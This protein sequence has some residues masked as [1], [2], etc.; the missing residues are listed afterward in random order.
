MADNEMASRSNDILLE[1]VKTTAR[2]EGQLISLISQVTG[3]SA[4]FDTLIERQ[5]TTQAVTATLESKT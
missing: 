4:K 1:L 2:S 3:M 5:G